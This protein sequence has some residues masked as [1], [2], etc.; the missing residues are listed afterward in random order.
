MPLDSG[1]L[2]FVCNVYT[3]V[4][5]TSNMDIRVAVILFPLFPVKIILL[6]FCLPFDARV[7]ECLTNIKCRWWTW[8]DLFSW[9][10]HPILAWPWSYQCGP[11]GF[12]C[13]AGLKPMSVTGVELLWSWIL[14][15]I[16]GIAFIQSLDLSLTNPNKLRRVLVCF[17]SSSIFAHKMYDVSHPCVHPSGEWAVCRR[18]WQPTRVRRLRLVQEGVKL[19][20]TSPTGQW[21][22]GQ[23]WVG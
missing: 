23:E 17:M 15:N 20:G 9:M 2:K 22:L 12:L 7:K 8:I 18:T 1:L 16:S 5:S 10:A 6:M 4:S 19:P 11:F 14:F 13:G 21:L 3:D